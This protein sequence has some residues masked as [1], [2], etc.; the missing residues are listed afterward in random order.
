MKK[1]LLI[2]FSI[3]IIPSS[4]GQQFTDLNG[5]YLGQTPPGNIPV[6]FAPDIITGFVHG[7]MAISPKGDEI[8]WVINP[9]TDRI[10][11]SKLE[12]DIWTKPVL[13]DFVKDSLT[14]HNGGSAFSNDGER[15]F[16]FS[17]RSGG[18]GEFD[19]WYVERTDRGWSKPIN[20]GKPYNSI[21]NEKSP[22]I[23]K[24]GNAFCLRRDKAHKTIPL[25]FE[26]FNGNFSN[27]DSI[28]YIPEY[29]PWWNLFIIPEED[30]I[31]FTG[32]NKEVPS[33]EAD[34]YIRFKNKQ[35]QW[36]EP[37]NMGSDI[38]TIE[39]DRFPHV[40]PDGKYLFYKG[41]LQ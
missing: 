16:F 21:D 3:L 36:G 34:L 28:D 8:Y 20:A 5:D 12:N 6:V 1:A 30:Y 31:I 37:I 35:G 26:Y 15:L 4:F 10:M 25:C 41:R 27:P 23:S 11:Y 14:V 18:I 13:A 29:G 40:S 7:G 17:N 38:N 33:H 24:K 19:S 2:I 39:W 22:L 32:D 9:S